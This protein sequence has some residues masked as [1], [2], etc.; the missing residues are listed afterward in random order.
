MIRATSESTVAPEPKWPPCGRL[1]G[2][3][4]GRIALAISKM[5]VVW[6]PRSST[7][8]LWAEVRLERKCQVRVGSL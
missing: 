8:A 2:G 6:R 3:Q 7:Y 4:S 1:L 5:S